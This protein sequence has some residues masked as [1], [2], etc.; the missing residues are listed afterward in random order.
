MR[1]LAR[2]AAVLA[3]VALVSG[4]IACDDQL[5]YIPVFS[6]MAEQPSIEAYEQPAR[7]MPAG[8]VALGSQRS[9]DLQEATALL[10]PLSIG[11]ED[12]E[13]G[14]EIFQIYCSVCHGTAGRGD[15]AVV[16][17]NRIPAIPTL[18][19]HSEQARA[20][21]DGYIWGMI[22]NGRGLMPSYRRIPA[23]LRWEVVS[24]V[25]ALQEGRIE[26]SA[27]E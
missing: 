25:R 10:N 5:K 15:G 17:P 8:A 1:P 4:A 20:Y 6:S 3:G 24:Y 2:R 16:G 18:D 21:T 9:Y 7:A 23:H 27:A 11:S 12:L 26:P 22:T 13:V 19:L 14:G